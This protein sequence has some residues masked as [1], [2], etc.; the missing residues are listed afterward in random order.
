MRFVSPHTPPA[1]LPCPLPA[2]PAH[3]LPARR[4]EATLRLRANL[5]V[6]SDA[7][8]A[9][10]W[11]EAELDGGAPVAIPPAL[12]YSRRVFVTY[13]DD[14]LGVVRDESGAPTVLMRASGGP[15]KPPASAVA[16]AVAD[17]SLSIL[18]EA[19]TKANLAD[20]LSGPGPFTVFA[21]TND[22]FVKALGALKL[23]KAE[24]LALPNLGE[25]L[26]YHV[27]PGQASAPRG[28]RGRGPGTAPQQGGQ[29]WRIWG[30]AAPPRGR[31]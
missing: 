7:R 29:Q 12:Q 22:A 13:L 28:P 5:D 27:V 3:R 30:G 16:A 18:V 31:R 4:S 6:E 26:K 2:P 25:I 20:A 15:P 9:E 8:L 23:T 1:P 10:T 14:T 19:V 17:P 24:L 11:L 21:P